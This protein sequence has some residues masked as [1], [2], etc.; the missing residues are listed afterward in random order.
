MPPVEEPP[1]DEPP[2]ALPASITI[3]AVSLAAFPSKGRAS[4]AKEIF[5]VAPS[6]ALSI[7]RTNG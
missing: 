6:T 4:P 7:R 3:A 1:D 5:P 2:V